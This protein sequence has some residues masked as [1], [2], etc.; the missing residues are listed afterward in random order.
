MSPKFLQKNV[1]VL[2]NSKLGNK[3]SEQVKSHIDLVSTVVSDFFPL[4]CIHYAAQWLYIF[5]CFYLLYI[6]V[7]CFCMWGFFCMLFL[8]AFT[9]C[10]QIKQ[11]L[12]SYRKATY[13]LYTS[14]RFTG[15]AGT[16][17]INR[18]CRSL[19]QALYK[20][21]HHTGLGDLEM[22]KITGQ[23]PEQLSI[24]L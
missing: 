20:L 18:R 23:C 9:M 16:G 21:S 17:T 3:K 15:Y 19:F 2:W 8:Y 22:F 11:A 1:D 5:V 4:F 12:L 13:V 10:K 6:D 7:S 24:Q 14:K